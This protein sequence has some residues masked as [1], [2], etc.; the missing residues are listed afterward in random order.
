MRF[1]IKKKTSIIAF[2]VFRRYMKIQWAYSDTEK[3]SDFL[4]VL[5]T[6]LR[7]F[8]GLKGPSIFK[9]ALRLRYYW[10][11]CHVLLSS[12]DNNSAFI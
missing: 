7:V 2:S 9:M 4:C 8:Y 1:D 11:Y 5:Y 10:C 12:I 3:V 6:P